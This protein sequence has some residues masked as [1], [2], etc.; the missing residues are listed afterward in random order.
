MNDTH[1]KTQQSS[2]NNEKLINK[3]RIKQNRK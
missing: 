2:I 3:I 1:D